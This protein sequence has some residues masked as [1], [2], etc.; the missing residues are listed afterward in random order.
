MSR[1]SLLNMSLAGC[2]IALSSSPAFAVDSQL[3]I[4]QTKKLSIQQALGQ[5]IF[6]DTNLSNPPGQSCASCHDPKTAFSEPDLDLPV[7]KGAEEGKTGTIN[8]PTAMY[9]A[10]MPAFHFEPEEGLFVGGQFL[11]G[12]EGTLEDQAKQPFINPDEM[13]NPDKASVVEKIRQADYAADFKLVYGQTALD[14]IETAYDNV[15][16]ALASFE[17]S[18]I[19]NPFTSKYDYYLAGMVDL[20]EQEARGLQLFEAEDKGNCAACHP[21]TPTDGKPPLFTDFTYDNLGA[22]SN[23]TILAAKGDDFIDIGLGKTVVDNPNAEAGADNG[24]FKVSTLRNISKTAPYMHN[25][26]F[27]DLREVVEFYNTRD[28]DDKWDK[29][30]I[31]EGVNTE[32][33]GNLKLSDQEID[34]IVAFMGTLSDGYQLGAQAEMNDSTITLPYIRVE[35]RDTTSKIYAVTLDK[36]D[37]AEGDAAQYQV[38]ELTELSLADNHHRT[39]IPYYSLD[40]GILE[41]PTI[42]TTNTE[43]VKTASVMQFKQA[44]T[45]GDLVFELSYSKAF[46]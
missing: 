16:A 23:K 40:T 42:T 17:R 12:R 32:E 25:G 3:S 24:K 35:G 39:D 45:A 9:T 27:A 4:E 18:P 44:V 22:P 26:V 30:E 10:F 6:F 29:P 36:L 1:P 34:D 37:T 19:F 14:D 2:I 20:S 46:Q 5:K 15:A 7:S 11:D 43:G 8:T 38:S 41:I 13:A 28:I 33:L 21:S 31:A